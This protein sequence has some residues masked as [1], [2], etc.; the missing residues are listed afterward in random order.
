MVESVRGITMFQPNDIVRAHGK[1]GHICKLR[2]PVIAT[3]ADGGRKV[4][5]IKYMVAW[6]EGDISGW[7]GEE[8]IELVTKEGAHE[9]ATITTPN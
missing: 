9:K 7:L 4:L 8:E 3:Y 6:G 5:P 1:V 2:P